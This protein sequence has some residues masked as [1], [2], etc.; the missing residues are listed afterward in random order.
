MDKMDK[1]IC[2]SCQESK[3]L[4]EYSNDR[5]RPDG[6]MMLKP[7]C[8]RCNSERVKSYN[9]KKA[10]QN[11][12]KDSLQIMPAFLVG[13]DAFTVDELEGLMQLLNIKD[14]LLVMAASTPSTLSTPIDKG[15]LQGVTL[16]KTFKVYQSVLDRFNHYIADHQ[17]KKIQDII[18][19]AL[20]EYID[21]H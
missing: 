18:S 21:K 9:A 6:T 17:G 15:E 10:S 13:K 3:P 7:I 14:Q 11:I 5:K 1:K 4:S 19:M 20:I 2:T 12:V 16:S 8:K